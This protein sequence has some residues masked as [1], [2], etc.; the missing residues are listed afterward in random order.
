MSGRT[1]KFKNIFLMVF[2]FFVG[3]AYSNEPSSYDSFRNTP[4]VNS[5]FSIDIKDNLGQIFSGT[6]F[7][8]GDNRFVTNAHVILRAIS[9]SATPSLYFFYK[10]KQLHFSKLLVLDQS[11]DLVI[12]TLKQED[13][14]QVEKDL[15]P[16]EIAA[17]SKMPS[18]LKGVSY[19]FSSFLEEMS[20]AKTTFKAYESNK[21]D[22]HTIQ[23]I[24]NADVLKGMSGSPVM[25]QG[26]VIG[27]L[28]KTWVNLFFAT[29]SDTLLSLLKRPFI[30][31]DFNAL[32]SE[33]IREQMLPDGLENHESFYLDLVDRYLKMGQGEEVVKIMEEQFSNLYMHYELAHLF[34]KNGDDQTGMEI[35]NHLS[36]KGINQAIWDMGSILFKEGYEWSKVK[37]YFQRAALRGFG[38][39][40]YVMGMDA[41]AKGLFEEASSWF[42][43]SFYQGYLPA[44]FKLSDFYKVYNPEEAHAHY[45]K[46]A[47]LISSQF[48]EVR[49][50]YDEIKEAQKQITGLTKDKQQNQS[51]CLE[52]FLKT[53]L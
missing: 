21:R 32:K 53:Y 13:F 9:S 33:I 4:L 16:L 30:N 25:V 14:K 24:G 34:F 19:G 7:Y 38:P 26:K 47:Y 39:S 50:K 27:I 2:I 23:L 12:L 8:I 45:M 49:D 17:T 52:A 29:K 35:L 42:V 37:R 18:H 31:K 44:Y 46:R 51:R 43:K 22:P 36:K 20:F 40:S 10:R 5:I 15:I 28:K 11:N 1:M 41:D 6:I 3:F 48:F